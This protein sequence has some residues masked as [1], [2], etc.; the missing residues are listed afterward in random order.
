MRI[1]IKTTSNTNLIGFD[2]QQKLVGV[3]HK[4]IGEGNQLHGKISLYSFSWLQDGK[5]VGDGLNFAHGA[6]FFISFH[7]ESVI[8]DIVRSILESPEMFCGMEVSDV[9]LLPD[10]DLSERSLFYLASPVFLHHRENES[11]PYKHYTFEDERSAELMTEIL[12]KKME[13]AG[14]PKDETLKVCFDLSYSN[15]RVKL[16]SYKGINN[17]ASMC[18]VIIEGTPLSKQFAW[19]V[20]IGNS[21]GIGFGAIY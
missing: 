18:P 7:D 8:K 16:M 2:Y 17:K 11:E 6:R 12:K 3:L 5:R 13:I 20:G 9:S 4:W 19:N 15:K 1:L 14:L 10:P 21:T